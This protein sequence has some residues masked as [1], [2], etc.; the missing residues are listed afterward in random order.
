MVGSVGGL[1][2]KAPGMT[3]E[4]ANYVSPVRPLH[5]NTC[6][7]DTGAVEPKVGAVP[8]TII[9]GIMY[10]LRTSKF[11]RVRRVRERTGNH[12]SPSPIFIIMVAGLSTSW[13]ASVLF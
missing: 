8:H 7:T 11:R 5:T 3:A 13:V 1:G 2:D 9:W 4:G 10:R 6:L 12:S